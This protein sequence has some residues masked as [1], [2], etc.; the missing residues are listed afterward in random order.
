MKL[1]NKLKLSFV[2]IAIIPIAMIFMFL[3]FISMFQIA[4]MEKQYDIEINEITNLVDQTKL[5]N[6]LT[7]SEVKGL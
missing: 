6:I 4:T 7:K 2:I 5:Y 1:K 3:Y